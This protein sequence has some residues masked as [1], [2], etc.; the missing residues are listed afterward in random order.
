MIYLLFYYILIIFKV[1][2]FTS[3]VNFKNFKVNLFTSIVKKNKNNYKLIY[4]IYIKIFIM[5][6]VIS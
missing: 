3:I 2:L 6:K 4:F 1:N 5:K